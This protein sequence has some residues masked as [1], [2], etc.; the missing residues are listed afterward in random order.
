MAGP[1]SPTV[2]SRVRLAH[3]PPPARVDQFPDQ[4]CQLL[5]HPRVTLRCQN[6]CTDH[7]ERY[8]RRDLARMH[9]LGFAFHAN[10][11]RPG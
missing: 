9:H 1:A 4:A 5:D 11:H 6:V 3:P 10:G 2:Q 7:K 8:Y